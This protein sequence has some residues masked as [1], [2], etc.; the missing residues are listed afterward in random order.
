LHLGFTGPTG[1]TRR[2]GRRQPPTAEARYTQ[3][4]KEYIERV[5][6]HTNWNVSR[7]A[8]LLDIQRTHLHQKMAAHG[9]ERRGRA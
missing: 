9:I 5:L 1:T 8:E 7:A 4:E 2:A 3:C 6:Q